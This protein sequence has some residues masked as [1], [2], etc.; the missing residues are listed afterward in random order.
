GRGVPAIVPMMPLIAAS[1]ATGSAVTI[2]LLGL[3]SAVPALG[4]AAAMALSFAGALAYLGRTREIALE[5]KAG[6]VIVR[7]GGE[8]LAR[9]RARPHALVP[10]VVNGELRVVHVLDGGGV[11]ALEVPKPTPEVAAALR[12]LFAASGPRVRV[13]AR[14]AEAEVAAVALPAPAVALR[15]RSA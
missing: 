5:R 7:S 4:S 15:Q 3:G 1:A 11:E 10:T 14:A 2:A 12:A 8:V 13:A 9:L 6:V